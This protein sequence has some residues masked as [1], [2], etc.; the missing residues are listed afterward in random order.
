VAESEGEGTN[1]L[2]SVFFCGDANQPH[3]SENHSH[4][5]VVRLPAYNSGN[6]SDNGPDPQVYLTS[7]EGAQDKVWRFTPYNLVYTTGRERGIII[8]QENPKR[9]R[10]QR[11]VLAYVARLVTAMG[12]YHVPQIVNPSDL[13][14]VKAHPIEFLRWAVGILCPTLRTQVIGEVNSQVPAFL[15][16]P[17]KVDVKFSICT[18]FYVSSH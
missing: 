8:C 13:T 18:W 3:R 14:R 6:G 4:A 7:A 10:R 17:I 2:P 12:A 5:S 16:P 1:A 15:L 9:S 11:S